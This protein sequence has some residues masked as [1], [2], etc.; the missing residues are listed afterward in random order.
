MV[1]GETSRRRMW[2]WWWLPAVAGAYR[3]AMSKRTRKTDMHGTSREQAIPVYDA[4]VARELAVMTDY[5]KLTRSLAAIADVEVGRLETLS[6]AGIDT[7]E[8]ERAEA[9]A[10]LTKSIGAYGKTVKRM[11]GCG[12]T[13][14]DI[15][16]L[17]G[18]EVNELRLALPYAS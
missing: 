10:Q 8:G 13:L 9:A 3:S 6:A 7:D 11:L 1:D 17:T 16:H 12:K 4:D 5:V 15:A 14:T 2:F 18:L